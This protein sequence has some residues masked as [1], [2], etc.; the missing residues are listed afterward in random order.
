MR[1]E[2][3]GEV[4]QEGERRWKKHPRKRTWRG[5]GKTRQETLRIQH[6]EV[7]RDGQ[8]GRKRTEAEERESRRSGKDKQADRFQSSL[9]SRLAN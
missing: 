6:K 3:G 5:E 1:G 9:L 7:C 2:D 8:M 4:R